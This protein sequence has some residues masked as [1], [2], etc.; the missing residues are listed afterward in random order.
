VKSEPR[1]EVWELSSDLAFARQLSLRRLCWKAGA[2]GGTWLEVLY[3]W[4]LLGGDWP[5][6]TGEYEAIDE[7]YGAPDEGKDAALSNLLDCSTGQWTIK[8]PGTLLKLIVFKARGL[9]VTTEILQTGGLSCSCPMRISL[10]PLCL[11]DSVFSLIILVGR[12]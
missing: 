4:A 11:A 12:L 3:G 9:A 7:E 6:D 1:T 10:S 8:L 2:F 5:E